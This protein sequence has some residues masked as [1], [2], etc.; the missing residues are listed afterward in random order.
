LQLVPSTAV[1]IKSE[2]SDFVIGDS[3][4]EQT[5]HAV[6]T[7]LSKLPNI[8]PW[9]SNNLSGEINMAPDPRAAG[10]LAI[11]LSP[12]FQSCI[13][14]FRP[15]A[16]TEHLWAGNPGQSKPASK[17]LIKR[18]TPR[19]SFATWSETV[20]NHSQSWTEQDEEAAHYF[21]VGFMQ[22]ILARAQRLSHD[23]RGLA[24]ESRAKDSFIN[25]VSHE[26]RTPLSIMIGW[27]DLL[28]HQRNDPAMVSKAIDIIERSAET[29]LRLID[30]LLDLSRIMSGKMRLEPQPNVSVTSI[31]TDL[32]GTF[33]LVAQNKQINLRM[34]HMDQVTV[35]ADPSRLRQ[36]VSNLVN[37]ALKFTP[38]GGAITV[39]VS[40][41]QTEFSIIVEDTGIGL[42]KE[43]LD[44]ISSPFA[45]FLHPMPKSA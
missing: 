23:F 28:K 13:V 4:S 7:H 3:P 8:T 42:S 25:T 36:V 18:L 11:P 9:S 43:N 39:T 35:V 40:A 38:K 15:D 30:D 6:V 34:G 22:R 10:A 20:H 12:E 14:W 45:R 27:I 21:M 29:Q 26:L 19:G 16:V 17:N 31:V 33:T 1:L 5:L 24:E 2:S 44:V 41:S 32:L 37:N